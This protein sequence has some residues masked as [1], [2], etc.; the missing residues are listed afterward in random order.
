[1][2]GAPTP[3]E[4]HIAFWTG[5]TMIVYGGGVPTASAGSLNT[6]GLYDPLTDSWTSISTDGAPF[7]VFSHFMSGVWTGTELIAWSGTGARYSPNSD[8]WTSVSPWPPLEFKRN[9]AAVWTGSLMIVW[10]GG[11]G[12]V[13]DTG[14]IYEPF[15]SR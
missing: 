1:M 2:T 5:S 12:V 9:H 13:Q 4:M 3:R 8:S 14:G 6:G 10:G 11:F 15:S 7:T